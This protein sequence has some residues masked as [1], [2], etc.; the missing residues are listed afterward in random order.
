MTRLALALL[1]GA[2]ARSVTRSSLATL[3]ARMGLK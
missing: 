3:P 2:V 1:V